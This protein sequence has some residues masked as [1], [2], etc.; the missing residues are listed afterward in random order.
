MKIF[1]LTDKGPTRAINQDY[2]RTEVLTPP[3]RIK[4]ARK[5]EET[6]FLAVVCDGMGGT[7][8]GEVASHLAADAL[9]K[10]LIEKAK[11]KPSR[12]ALGALADAL[13]YANGAVYNAAL[14]N[15]AL[16]GM[17]ST[18]VAAL[19]Y[20]GALAILSV[21]DS[22]IY[23]WHAGHLLLLTHDHSYVQSM[24]DAGRMSPLEARRSRHRNLITRAVGTRP[25][26]EADIS[27]CCWE[28]G[29]KLLLCTDGIVGAVDEGEISS[30]LSED[31]PTEH[32]VERLIDTAVSR[33]CEDN[34]TALLIENT[35][36]NP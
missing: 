18:M 29:D 26:V 23:L 20:A 22:R 24:V 36:E 12:D 35:K 9:I 3:P 6:A 17:G 21:G 32:T 8:G 31:I 13:E 25:S 28:E 27:Y 5:R 33:G 15:E 7:K 2:F 34:L 11:Q 16:R 14:Q 19:A 30:I 10:N 1:G 4:G